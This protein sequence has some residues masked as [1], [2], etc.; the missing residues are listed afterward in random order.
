MRGREGNGRAVDSWRAA[1][2]FTSPVGGDVY[3]HCE[4]LY[5]TIPGGGNVIFLHLHH[6]LETGFLTSEMQKL[7]IFISTSSIGKGGARRQ[8]VKFNGAT[9]GAGAWR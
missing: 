4:V 7:D 1:A 8:T 6:L 5:F 3:L 9:G 2:I